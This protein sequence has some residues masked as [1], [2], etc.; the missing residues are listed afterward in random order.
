MPA[1]MPT[2]TMQPMNQTNWDPNGNSQN[3]DNKDMNMTNWNQTGMNYT[4]MNMNMSDW[5]GTEMGMN[6]WN[7]TDMEWNPEGGNDDNAM[8]KEIKDAM[9]EIAD[10]LSENEV[11]PMGNDWEDLA[12]D[13]EDGW[14]DA[15]EAFNEAVDSGEFEENDGRSSKGASLTAA[16][17]ATAL[18][19][20]AAQF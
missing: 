3:W 6:N 7:N 17:V 14:K 8:P 18:A 5:N 4:D 16:F 2:N 20:T 10:V 1:N 12:R 13:I 11:P 19:F 15:A 9:Y